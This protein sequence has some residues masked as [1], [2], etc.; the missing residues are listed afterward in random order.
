MSGESAAQRYLPFYVCRVACVNWANPPEFYYFVF[1]AVAVAREYFSKIIVIYARHR[2][3]TKTK[4]NN[5]CVQTS[6]FGFILSWKW[7]YVCIK[8]EKARV[9]RFGMNKKSAKCTPISCIPSMQCVVAL[10]GHVIVHIVWLS[11]RALFRI[12]QVHSRASSQPNNRPPIRKVLSS[13]IRP[14]SET[15]KMH[16]KQYPQKG[17]HTMCVR[18][19]KYLWDG[20]WAHRTLWW[21]ESVQKRSTEPIIKQPL[22]IRCGNV[23]N[24]KFESLDYELIIMM[25]GNGGNTKVSWA[26]SSK[27][28][29]EW[30]R[31]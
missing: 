21:V 17:A 30:I 3:G 9:S 1:V 29:M 24:N 10:P 22:F 6:A 14:G 15:Q 4:N 8:N 27:H 5:N 13:L 7:V 12:V 20:L 11:Q 26:A 25:I 31:R 16:L 2:N 28:H 23:A 18:L 19:P